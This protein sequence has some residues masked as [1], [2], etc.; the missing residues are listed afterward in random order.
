MQAQWKHSSRSPDSDAV[1][2]GVGLA[3]RMQQAAS[4]YCGEPQP[5]DQALLLIGREHSGARP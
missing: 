1:A 3:Y 4:T 5:E 2:S